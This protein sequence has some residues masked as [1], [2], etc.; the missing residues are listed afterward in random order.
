[1]SGEK[2]EKIVRFNLRLCVFGYTYIYVAMID[3]FKLIKSLIMIYNGVKI[4]ATYIYKQ[5][6]GY[7]ETS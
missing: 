7:Y 2:P 6:K 3:H 1:M 5:L 4:C